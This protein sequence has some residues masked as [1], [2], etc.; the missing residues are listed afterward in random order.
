MKI[1]QAGHIYD[2]HSLDVRDSS[3]VTRA[4][5]RL[6]FVNREPGHEHSGT[7]TQEVLRALIDRTMH[8]DNCLRWPGN[9]L[10]IYHL[11]MALTLHESR[12]L[13][14]KV[15]KGYIQPENIITNNH[16]GHFS[17]MHNGE[18]P[19]YE[20]DSKDSQIYHGKPKP[21]SP[22]K[23]EMPCFGKAEV[24]NLPTSC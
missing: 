6:V 9:D 19:N 1:I 23:P 24:N 18:C 4:F 20:P 13:L 17:I 2:L 21:D 15:E 3:G 10:I 5:E 8:C 7:Q 14:R 11:R 22:L 16:D 12:A